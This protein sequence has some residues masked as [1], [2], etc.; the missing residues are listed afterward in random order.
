M[1]LGVD[2]RHV[3]G[4]D[5]A[6]DEVGRDRRAV[7]SARHRQGLDDHVGVRREDLGSPQRERLDDPRV[8]RIVAVHEGEDPARVDEQGHQRS[9]AS[10]AS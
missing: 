8:S 2:R 9:P 10:S 4:R 1:Q 6:V 3:Q 7:A 5:D